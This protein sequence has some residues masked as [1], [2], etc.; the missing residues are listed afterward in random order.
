M[1]Q[2]FVVPGKVS[3]LCLSPDA[4]Y[5]VAAIQELIHVWQVS[6]SLHNIL[7]NYLKTIV[8]SVVCAFCVFVLTTNVFFVTDEHRNSASNIGQ[9]LSI[10]DVYPLHG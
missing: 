5:C 6:K 8:V 10:C 7:Q 9:A 1:H 4:L 2:R 3:A